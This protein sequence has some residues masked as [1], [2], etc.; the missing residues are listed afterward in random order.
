MKKD[1]LKVALIPAVVLLVFA[2]GCNLT[3][4]T[5]SSANLS[6]DK[7]VLYETFCVEFDTYQTGVP[8]VDP[9]ISPL[10]A[11]EINAWLDANNVDRNDITHIFQSG[12][13]ILDCDPPSSPAHDWDITSKVTIRREDIA[14]G[15]KTYVRTMTVTVPDDLEYR[16]VYPRFGY[17]GVQLVNRA[18]W[19]LVEGGDPVLW[20]EMVGTDVDPEPSEADPLTFCW[21]ACVKI[22]VVV[23]TYYGDDDD[24]D[25]DWSDD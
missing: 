5:P 14:D 4:D 1:F 13:R 8:F 15:P 7:I 22:V 20:V 21:Q 18:L 16:G 2:S 9:P 12:G 17:Y 19:D 24:D 11:E 25:D 23:E 3:N 6:G 10:Y